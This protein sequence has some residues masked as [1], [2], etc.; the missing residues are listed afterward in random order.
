MIVDSTQYGWRY[1]YSDQEIA[2]LEQN[3]WWTPR[4]HTIE[5]LVK[6][7]HAWNACT[8]KDVR[9]MVI[10]FT[11]DL[12]E[13]RPWRAFENFKSMWEAVESWLSRPG[14][15]VRIENSVFDNDYE[16]Y[17]SNTVD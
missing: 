11:D 9:W 10:F 3:E 13:D 5:D 17:L 16:I 1:Y 14:Y 7:H 2:L 15:S 8:D 12:D 6:A 4:W